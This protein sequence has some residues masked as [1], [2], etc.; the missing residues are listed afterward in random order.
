MS[1]QRLGNPMDCSFSATSDVS[2]KA[3]KK[4]LSA[5]DKLISAV[6]INLDSQRRKGD[7]GLGSPISDP[8]VVRVVSAEE[9]EKYK[10][11]QEKILRDKADAILLEM[12]SESDWTVPKP[13][14]KFCS[15]TLAVFASV[16]GL[17]L[18]SQT[19]SFWA[20]IQSLPLWPRY[21]AFAGMFVFGGVILILIIALLWGCIR[22]QRSPQLNIQATKKLAERARLQKIALEKQADACE[23]LKRVLKDYPVSSQMRISLKSMSMTEEEWRSLTTGRKRLLDSDNPMSPTEWCEEFERCFQDV[24]D[25]VAKRRIRQYAKRVGVGTAASPI[26][27]VDRMIVLFSS[28][29]M[30]KDLLKIYQLRPAAGQSVITLAK[31]VTHIYLSGIIENVSEVAVD[32]IADNLAEF[33]EG[34]LSVLTGSVGRSMSSKATEATLNA[35]FLYRLGAKTVLMIK[36]VR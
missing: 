5:E 17:L 9:T 26:A 30:V 19:V 33:S 4:D 36:P 15:V 32:S 24:L 14:R 13:I 23:Q 22:L 21:F 28:F 3:E 29:A 18:I 7:S 31:A 1:Q 27:L 35:F 20:D 6:D 34:G 10:E 11:E 2:E 12:Q 16:L 25:D 8:S